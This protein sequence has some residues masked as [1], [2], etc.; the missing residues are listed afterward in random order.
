MEQPLFIDVLLEGTSTFG[1]KLN[2]QQVSAMVSYY[3]ELDRWSQKVNLTSIHDAR[4][5]AIKHFLDSLLYGQAL[6]QKENASLL[7]VGSGAG[8]PGLPLKILMPELH[9]TLLE[10]NAKKTSFLR[11]IIG[12]LDLRDASVVS[13]SLR[14]FS[15]ATAQHGRFAYITTRAVAAEQVLP[16]S[17]PLLKERGRVIFCLA[18]ILDD[19]GKHGFKISR[20]IGYDLPHGYGHRVLTVLE[21]T[22]IS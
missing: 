1:I 9:V 3:R 11:H 13:K 10:P 6:E 7:D 5:T 4:E 12:T 21:R 20:E 2:Q 14:D 22:A 8:F 16:Y 18:K 17:M 15:R 19:P